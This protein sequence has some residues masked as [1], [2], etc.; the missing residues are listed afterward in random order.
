MCQWIVR[1][2]RFPNLTSRGKRDRF[3]NQAVMDGL[4]RGLGIVG[5]FARYSV[6]SVPDE[7]AIVVVSSPVTLIVN[8]PS[9]LPDHAF[10]VFWFVK[11]GFVPVVK[12]K[13][14]AI[15]SLL[16]VLVTVV[17]FPAAST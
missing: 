10:G 9:Q 2:R 6:R 15:S 4:R 17:L 8:V 14:G 12:D 7:Q 1:Q 11:S 3:T 5:V 13:I 16:Y